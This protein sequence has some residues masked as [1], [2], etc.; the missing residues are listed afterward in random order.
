MYY[1]IKTCIWIGIFVLG[2]GVVMGCSHGS[3]PIGPSSIDREEQ[4]FG[5]AGTVFSSDGT[6]NAVARVPVLSKTTV[7]IVEACSRVS[8]PL[9]RMPKRAAR[10]VATIITVGVAKPRA[11]GQ[12]ITMTARK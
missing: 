10:P 11:Q 4:G 1:T 2:L 12:A 6:C 5:S 3:S 7:L 8:P 9:I